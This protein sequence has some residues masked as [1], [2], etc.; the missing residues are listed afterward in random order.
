MGH[1]ECRLYRATVR[2]EAS[3]KQLLVEGL[4]INK[5]SLALVESL[6]KLANNWLIMWYR[7]YALII[8]LPVFSSVKCEGWQSV[9]KIVRGVLD[10]RV[11]EEWQGV[12]RRTKCVK[13]GQGCVGSQ[14]VWRRTKCVK[15]SRVGEEGQSVWRMGGCVKK[16]KVCEEWQGV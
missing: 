9:W 7:T 6:N 8:F 5:A 16:D 14:G 4:Q 2:I 11:C 15:N 13:D 12:W 1:V 10:R 3:T